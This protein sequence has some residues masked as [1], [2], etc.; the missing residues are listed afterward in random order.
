MQQVEEGKAFESWNDRVRA[1]R[2]YVPG[3]LHETG[4]DAPPHLLVSGAGV[5]GP[6]RSE[7]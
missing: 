1:G 7:P 6:Q 4:H 5:S 2:A 3:G